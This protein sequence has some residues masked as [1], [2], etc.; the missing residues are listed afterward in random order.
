M[1]T[2]KVE[3]DGEKDLPILTKVLTDLGYSF[4]LENDEWSGL[5][6]DA[7]SGIEAGLLNWEEGKVYTSEEAET[8]INRKLA[9]LHSKYGK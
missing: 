6:V 5:P 3:I 1:T 4:R 7:I 9:E 8:R 2:L